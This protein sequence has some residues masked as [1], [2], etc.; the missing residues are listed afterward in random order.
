MK[1]LNVLFC[2][3]LFITPVIASPFLVS[4]PYP[5]LC[6]DNSNL[7][8][9]CKQSYPTNCPL[10]E[11]CTLPENCI[12]NKPCEQPSTFSMSIDS[13]TPIDISIILNEN[14]EPYF[15]YDLSSLSDANHT[16]E[17]STQSSNAKS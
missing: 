7:P 12:K 5:A 9:E 2:S 17:V 4:N 16:I 11:Y 10:P 15:R 8:A 1:L 13:G 3:L 14:N 6:C